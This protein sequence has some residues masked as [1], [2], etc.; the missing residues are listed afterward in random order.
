MRNIFE[1]ND[2]D[3]YS[4]DSNLTLWQKFRRLW[5]RYRVTRWLILVILAVGFVMEAYLLIG[6]KTTDVSDLPTKL[7]VTTEFYDQDGEYAGEISNDAGTYVELENIS[8]NIQD[9]VISTEDK[10]FYD[11]HGFDPIGIAR[12]AFGYVTSGQIVGGGSTITQ[13]LV[14]NAFLDN[15]QSLMRKLKEL[16]LA[17]EI[18][19][20]YTKEEI[21]EMYL[22]NAY[23]GNGAYGVEDASLKYFGVSASEVTVGDAA[24][25][26]GALKGPTIYNPVDDYDATLDRR[27]TIIQLMVDNEFLTQEEADATIH[28]ELVQMNNDTSSDAYAYPYYFDAVI[29]EA[30]DKFGLSEEDIMNGNYK[31]YTNLNQT[32]QAELESTYS[33]TSLFPTS[34]SGEL[35]QSASVVMDPKTG[36]VMASVGGT[37]DYSFR[38]FNRATQISRSPASTIKPL[39]VYAAALENGYT[40]QSVIPDEQKSYGAD[41]YS[42]ENWNYE[43]AGDILLWDAVAKSKNTTAVW[44]MNELGIQTTIAKLDDFGIPYTEEDKNLSLALGAF[45]NGGVSP[46]QM[47]SAYSAFANGGVRSE[48]QYI[49][50]IEDQQGNIVVEEQEPVQN[51]A[52]S[53]EVADEMTAVLMSVYD[54]GGTGATMEPEGYEIAG[55]TG[56]AESANFT[57]GNADEWDIAYT[58]D[59]V[60]ATWFGFDDTDD[61]TYLWYGSAGSSKLAFS[62]VLS[63][64]LNSSPGTTF[65][66]QSA[67]DEYNQIQSE[68]A[69]ISE[70]SSSEES[71][72]DNESEDRSVL[73]SVQEFF[74]GLF[75]GQ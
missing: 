68:Q 9:A 67:Y 59:V 39:L 73:D 21:L 36:G 10:R 18:E 42:P 38:G 41:N 72:S 55:K 35:A 61:D 15:D 53:A 54:E 24:V 65:S 13:Q 48:G 43:Y 23:F 40:A 63:G 60:I 64:I 22:N 46:L 3:M 50:R 1:S 58:P 26:A 33:D 5:Q 28:T 12:A 7:Q 19:K 51:Q 6:A 29:N 70:E 14:K 37:G 27:N 16:F 30:I 52:V 17:F 57:S 69:T 34:P 71:S 2:R 20:N 47:A 74:Q 44:L 25:I 75:G 8:T 49:T 4:D 11:H 31:I 45:N 56:S 32:Y 66:V 62:D